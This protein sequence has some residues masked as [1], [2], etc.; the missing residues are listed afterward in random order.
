MVWI[1]VMWGR[2]WSSWD[3]LQGMHAIAGLGLDFLVYPLPSWEWDFL[4]ARNGCCCSWSAQT[5]LNYIAIWNE[6]KTKINIF[7]MEKLFR[8]IKELLIRKTSA[9]QRVHVIVNTA[10]N[11]LT[12]W[13]IWLD[14][15]IGI[16]IPSLTPI[17]MNWTIGSGVH[18]RWW[19]PE[20]L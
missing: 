16:L 8:P 3:L 11:G 6:W 19:K 15:K 20:N 7:C 12:L 9:K 5:R 10:S 2:W 13:S 4:H 18:S 14:N 1:L 17:W